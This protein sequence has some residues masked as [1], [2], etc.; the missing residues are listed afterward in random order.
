MFSGHDV[1]YPITDAAHLG[2]GPLLHLSHDPVLQF[3][4]RTC[5][6]AV[7]DV[8]KEEKRGVARPTMTSPLERRMPK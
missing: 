2:H 7:E 8:V 5:R 4:M 3:F 6:F 1:N